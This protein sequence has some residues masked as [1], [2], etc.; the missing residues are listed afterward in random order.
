MAVIIIYP[1][2][3]TIDSH[4]IHVIHNNNNDTLFSLDTKY[5]TLYGILYMCAN[6]SHS[7]SLKILDTYKIRKTRYT[8]KALL[9]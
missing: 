8:L 6:P 7:Y 4:I 3:N 9:I 2:N 1:I 5:I